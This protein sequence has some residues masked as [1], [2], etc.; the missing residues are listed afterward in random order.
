MAVVQ[1]SR[2]SITDFSREFEAW[3]R[4]VNMPLRDI[5]QNKEDLGVMFQ[6][7]QITK[8]TEEAEFL[9]HQRFIIFK[10]QFGGPLPAGTKS[11]YQ[12]Q[13]EAE[14]EDE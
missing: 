10:L 6:K 14:F 11:L 12:R 5:L 8:G 3:G 13:A 9:L 2:L 1:N 7:E 4:S